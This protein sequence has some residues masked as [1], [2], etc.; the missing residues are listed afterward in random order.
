MGAGR[1]VGGGKFK[2]KE[3]IEKTLENSK[4]IKNQIRNLKIHSPTKSSYSAT[5]PPV[6]RPIRVILKSDIKSPSTLDEFLSQVEKLTGGRIVYAGGQPG[7][8]PR[9]FVLVIEGGDGEWNLSNLVNSVDLDFPIIIKNIDEI[10]KYL[11]PPRW[12]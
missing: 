12:G 4:I 6:I 3:L 1:P 2:L 11:D 9:G 10:H 7:I 8:H 5:K